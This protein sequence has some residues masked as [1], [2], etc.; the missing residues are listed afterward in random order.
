MKNYFK[1]YVISCMLYCYQCAGS[2]TTAF[3][4]PC[5]INR[6]KQILRQNVLVYPLVNKGSFQNMNGER[7]ILFRSKSES[8]VCLRMTLDFEQYRPMLTSLVSFLAVYGIL[9]YIIFTVSKNQMTNNPSK[10]FGGNKNEGI[11]PEEVNVK[12]EDVAGIDYVKTEIQDILDYLKD[13]SK[14][15]KMGASVPTGILLTGPPGTGKTLIAKAIATEAKVPF[16]SSD[17]SKFV[18][19]FIGVG[20][21]RVRDLFEKA[22]KSAPAI[23]F[24]DEIEGLTGI[25]GKSPVSNNDEREN[26]LNSLLVEMDGFSSKADKTK[27]VIVIG[28]TNR[29]DMIDPAVLRPGR[30]DRIVSVSLPDRKAR[31]DILKVHSKNKPLSEAINFDD[32]ASQTIGKNGADL[33]NI[34]NEASIIALRKNKNVIDSIDI[35]EALDKQT[36]GIALPNKE[37]SEATNY[38]VATHEIGHT[39]V[40]LLLNHNKVNRVSIVPTSRGIGGITSIVP[41]DNTVDSGIVSKTYLLNELQVLLG[42]RIAEEIM[43]G[44]SL[45][46]TGA[47]SD[48]KRARDLIKSFLVDYAMKDCFGYKFEDQIHLM[49]QEYYKKTYDLLNENKELLVIYSRVLA[50]KKNLYTED[51]DNIIKKHNL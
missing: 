4:I 40:S 51:I 38:L 16:F 18:E 7:L 3:N 32:I 41:D 45:I 5:G 31:R 10:F 14:F 11:N 36:V 35:F 22:R 9:S 13:P 47:S 29:M 26:T 50:D 37:R 12:F 33:S 44:N 49:L 27:P 8:K 42:G 6:T 48:I 43:F 28:A 34:M 1:L 46:T 23:V 39:L 19:I 20:S 25:R 24:I 2:R 21:Q 15:E 30:F 17:G